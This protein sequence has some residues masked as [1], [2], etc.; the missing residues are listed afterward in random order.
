MPKDLNTDKPRTMGAAGPDAS[1]PGNAVGI[2]RL[3][4]LTDG[5]FAIAM[6][7]LVLNIQVPKL[8]PHAPL[9]SM[10][11]ALLEGSNAFTD[12]A[13]SFFILG[14]V[15]MGNAHQLRQMK[16]TSRGHMSLNLLCLMLA[17]LIPYT[18]S[19]TS[20]YPGSVEARLFFHCNLLLVGLAG[21]AQWRLGMGDA[22]LAHRPLGENE[23]KN[24]SRRALVL[25]ACAAL[26]MPLTFLSPGYSSL[27][28]LL[29]P[30]VLAMLKLR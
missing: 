30:L 1:G 6:T 10:A 2:N 19:L 21:F 7:I 26:A 3:E 20:A 8:P 11:Q 16:A 25:P 18:T 5:I 27:I 28:Y 24:G 13:I 12:Y 23:R 29:S 17:C 4:A 22:R 14:M 15:W 9:G